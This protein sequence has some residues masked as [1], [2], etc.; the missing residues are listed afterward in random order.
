MVHYCT[1]YLLK[2]LHFGT[3]IGAV[4]RMT[5]FTDV[6]MILAKLPIE[7]R[8]GKMILLSCIFK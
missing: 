8:L 7:P 3:E 2:Y 4:T 6:G 1:Y 5:E